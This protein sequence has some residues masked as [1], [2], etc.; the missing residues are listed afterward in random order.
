MQRKRTSLNACRTKIFHL[1][2]EQAMTIV[3]KVSGQYHVLLIFTDGQAGNGTLQSKSR[4]CN[5][6][7]DTE[8][9][10]N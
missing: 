6:K 4:C 3:G 8:L 1:L 9:A 7:K 10:T 2:I 5:M